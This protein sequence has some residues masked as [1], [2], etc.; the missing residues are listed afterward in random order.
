M[1]TYC[2]HLFVSRIPD[3]HDLV[4]AGSDQCAAVPVPSD[5]L[6][7]VGVS[8]FDGDR[9]FLVLKVKELDIDITRCG[10][11]NVLGDGMEVH[12]ED[13]VLVVA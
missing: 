2:G 6:H 1:Q 13:S 7:N 8:A 12:A 4:L 11:Q 3:A 9:F 10:D 5:R